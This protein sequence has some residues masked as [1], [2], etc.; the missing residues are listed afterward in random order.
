MDSISIQKNRQ[1]QQDKGDGRVY[2]IKAKRLFYYIASCRFS[3]EI[4]ERY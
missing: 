1:D 3:A 2:Q 4:D